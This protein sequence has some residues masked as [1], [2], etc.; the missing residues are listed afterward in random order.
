M[1]SSSSQGKYQFLSLRFSQG[2]AEDGLVEVPC[3]KTPLEQNETDSALTFGSLSHSVNPG[4]QRRPQ[5]GESFPNYG[6]L[7]F[8]FHIHTQFHDNGRPVPLA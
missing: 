5:K 8:T 7:E 6:V 2:I 3:T 1:A 4:S